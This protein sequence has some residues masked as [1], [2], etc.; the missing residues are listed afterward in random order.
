M[1]KSVYEM[2]QVVTEKNMF[3]KFCMSNRFLIKDSTRMNSNIEHIYSY[4]QKYPYFLVK[5][6][7]H[8]DQQ[9]ARTVH[10]VF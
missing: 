5:F 4:A 7:Y 9:K 8:R 2:Y 10:I 6:Q 3:L 1:V